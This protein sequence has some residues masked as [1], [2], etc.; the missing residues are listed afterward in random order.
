MK[1]NKINIVSLCRGAMIAG[2]YY[3]LCSVLAPVAF[4]PLQV[5]VAEGMTVLL[6][7]CPEAVW[8]LTLG[9]FLANLSSPYLFYDL[10]LGTLATLLSCVIGRRIKKKWL[11]GLPAVLINALV[12]GF[13]L[14]QVEAVPFWMGALSVGAGQ[15]VAVYGVG[16]V[17]MLFFEKNPRLKALV[18][19]AR[20]EAGR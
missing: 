17:V 18:F 7:F 3:V 16:S 8:G 2:I 14:Y 11:V 9:C 20:E 19:S 1:E 13:M 12:V 4:G 10:I 5:R 15:F 6:F